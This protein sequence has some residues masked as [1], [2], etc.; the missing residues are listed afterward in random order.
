MNDIF[1]FDGFMWLLMKYIYIKQYTH[2]N[3]PDVVN[4]CIVLKKY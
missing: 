3:S 4:A 2:E 1:L